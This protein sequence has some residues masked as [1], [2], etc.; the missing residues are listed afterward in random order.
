MPNFRD[1]RLTDPHATF[2]H[3]ISWQPDTQAHER[4]ADNIDAALQSLPADRKDRQAAK[5]AR[6]QFV[7]ERR[8][9]EAELERVADA[10][11]EVEPKRA[12]ALEA[13]AKA[14]RAFAGI[15]RAAT[16]DALVQA[17]AESELAVRAARV[18][19]AEFRA[20]ALRAAPRSVERHALNRGQVRAGDV[21]DFLRRNEGRLDDLEEDRHTHAE[22][23]AHDG[24][25][26]YGADA[27]PGDVPWVIADVGDEECRVYRLWL[28]VV[29]PRLGLEAPTYDE[30]FDTAD[31]AAE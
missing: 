25:R 26:S 1:D 30:I 12:V 27:H 14:D 22:A 28:S 13:K 17:R 20:V 2:D 10:M 18:A 15:A 23:T 3:V 9:V 31:A 5:W 24:A 21:L 8:A 7:A 29:G 11:A 19:L 4:Y 16:A 6:E